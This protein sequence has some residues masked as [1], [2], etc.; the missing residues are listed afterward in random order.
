MER[1]C[2]AVRYTIT[3]TFV[4]YG[5][6]L[7]NESATSASQLPDQTELPFLSPDQSRLE[8][9]FGLRSYHHNAIWEE[10]KH[11]TWLISIILSAQLLV[12]TGVRLDNLPK[13]LLI[14]IASIVGI[15]LSV[16]ALRVQ[17]REGEYFRNANARFVAEYNAVYPSMP[18]PPPGPVAN[19]QILS[20][21][22]SI[23]IGRS[24]VRDYFQFLF[25]AFAVVFLLMAIFAYIVL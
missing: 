19:K 1:E 15:L 5:A 21:V 13:A 12:L 14:S 7:V 20:L 18:M 8:F 24:G 11:F 23:F 22:V 4:L 10:Q 3:T 2:Y 9:A 25:L 6:S 16:T 17:R